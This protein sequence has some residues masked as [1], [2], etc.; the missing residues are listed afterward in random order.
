[1]RHEKCVVPLFSN[2]SKLLKISFSCI[3]TWTGEDVG[4]KVF[5]ALLH[6]VCLFMLQPILVLKS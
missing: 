5:A 3:G 4:I 1:M 2:G 6:L